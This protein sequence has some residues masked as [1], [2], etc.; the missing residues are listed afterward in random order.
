MFLS[1][2][3]IEAN[4][5]MDDPYW[6]DIGP[7]GADAAYLSLN[8]ENHDTV[9]EVPNPP[10]VPSSGE[11]LPLV[12]PVNDVAIGLESTAEARPASSLSSIE[13]HEKG[14]SLEE[15]EY[16]QDPM[17]FPKG[18]FENQSHMPRGSEFVAS[19]YVNPLHSGDSLKQYDPMKRVN[20][21][22]PARR[23]IKYPIPTGMRGMQSEI[24][25]E[26][27][28]PADWEGLCPVCRTVV[29]QVRADVRR[30]EHEEAVRNERYWN[31][32][33]FDEY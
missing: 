33:N 5:P 32:E 14:S 18:L 26:C 12:S 24:C 9:S 8:G 13:E 3:I 25:E 15:K 4:S 28:E 29:D 6:L 17:D 27:G 11:I 10:L 7:V 19:S 22:L 23:S 31:G 16:S 1:D 21:L 2:N 20:A 30:E